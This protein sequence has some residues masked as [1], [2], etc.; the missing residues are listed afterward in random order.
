MASNLRLNTV[1]RSF[2]EGGSFYIREIINPKTQNKHALKIDTATNALLRN[3]FF[4][5]DS[6]GDYKLSSQRYFGYKTVSTVVKD[7]E[8][9]DTKERKIECFMPT[10]RYKRRILVNP[11]GT[12]VQYISLDKEKGIETHTYYIKGKLIHTHIIQQVP[13]PLSFSQ[14]LVK[15]KD[16]LD[17]FLR[18]VFLF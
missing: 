2:Q 17:Y 10:K 11:D 1:K 7:I 8:T 18:E 5:K 13:E 4:V 9:G 16:K 6:H 14:K 12:N 15:F 3:D